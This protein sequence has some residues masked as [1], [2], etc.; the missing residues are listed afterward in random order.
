MQEKIFEDKI[1]GLNYNS[2]KEC[3]DYANDL[4]LKMCVENMPNME[5]YLFK[6][7]SKL[8]SALNEILKDIEAC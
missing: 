2:L 1:L 8:D 6:D 3:A 5:G 7:V 4:G